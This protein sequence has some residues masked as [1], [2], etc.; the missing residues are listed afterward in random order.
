MF[1]PVEFKHRNLLRNPTFFQL[2]ARGRGN[3]A[4]DKTTIYEWHWTMNDAL[5]YLTYRSSLSDALSLVIE[6]PQSSWALNP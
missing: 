1:I 4:K 5:L 2:S 6:D 3:A